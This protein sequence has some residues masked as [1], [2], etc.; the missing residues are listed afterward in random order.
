MLESIH[1]PVKAGGGAAAASTVGDGR[2]GGWER[3]FP[4]NT[5]AIFPPAELP[6]RTNPVSRETFL[7]HLGGDEEEEVLFTIQ[8]SVS[9]ASS[10]ALGQGCSGARR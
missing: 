4:T 9:Q 1:R 10:C 7:R 3:Y 8:T 5:A 2:V 6:A